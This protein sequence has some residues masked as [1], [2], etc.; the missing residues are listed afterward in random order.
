MQNRSPQMAQMF[1][2]PQPK[3]PTDILGHSHIHTCFN[4][5]LQSYV[6]SLQHH[7]ISPGV[8]YSPIRTLK[9]PF[10]S[11]SFQPSSFLTG[12]NPQLSFVFLLVDSSPPR[13]V[14]TV[15][16]CLFCTRFSLDC[17]LSEGR[18]PVTLDSLRLDE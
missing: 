13:S 4:F 8:G 3:H 14:H 18:G 7:L 6:V 17:E 2:Q 9:S 10:A 11:P 12:E 15:W 1:P 5:L 16:Q